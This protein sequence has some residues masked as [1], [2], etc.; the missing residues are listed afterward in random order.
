[1]PVALRTSKEILS[2]SLAAVISFVP[3]HVAG[4][5]LAHELHKTTLT[6][7]SMMSSDDSGALAAPPS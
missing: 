3:C 6:C 4:T 2:S 7:S 1:M 5:V